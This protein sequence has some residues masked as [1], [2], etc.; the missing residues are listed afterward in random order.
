MKRKLALLGATG[1]IG[2]NTLDVINAYGDYFDVVLL[3]AHRDID[4]LVEISKSFPSALL[5]VT[6]EKLRNKDT[7]VHYW[8]PSGLLDA[9]RD[10]SADMV[11]NGIA[12]AA[13]LL[14]SITALESG[15]DLALANKETIVMAGL[16]VFSIAKKNHRRIIPVDSEHSAVFQLLEAHGPD[17][18]EEI[19]LTASGGPFRQYSREQL[20]RVT[21]RDAL[22]HPTWTMGGKIT[23]DSA[24]L[25]NKGLEVIEAIRL[26]SLR[27]EQVSVLVHPQSFVH[28]LIRLKEG[29]LYAQL[30]KPDMRIPIHNAL[31]WP[32]IKPNQ[33]GRLSLENQN[34][35]FEKPKIDLFPLLSLAY[36]VAEL[37]TGYPVTFNAANEEAVA[38]FM[39]DTISFMDISRIVETVLQSD[40]SCDDR[41]LQSILEID[42]KARNV[43]QRIIK[44]F[45]H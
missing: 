8:G 38:A 35:S 42:T 21:L 9:I 14:P 2:T 15:A 1:S 34:L 22:A 12:G 39:S 13:G 11:V 33:F 6:D 28:S 43:A 25:A 3:S 18:V 7:R 17:A 20:Q 23:I 45:S 40:W 37:G 4:K 5:A 31:F 16:L 32:E 36:K 44:E 29:S 10:C 30:S 24:S 41:E 27:P 19:I 26:F